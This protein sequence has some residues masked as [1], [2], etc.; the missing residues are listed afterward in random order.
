MITEPLTK[1]KSTGKIVGLIELPGILA[2]KRLY[3]DI[4]VCHCHGVFDLVHVGHLRHFQKAKENGD[5]LVITLTPDRY[6]NKGP[7]RPAFNEEL[8]L[9]FIA[10]LE[11]VDYVALNNWPT[12]IETLGLIKPDFYIKGSEYS[13]SKNDITGMIEAEKHAV[14][15]A[16]GKLVFTDDVIFSS[17][18]LINNYMSLLPEPA[19]RFISQLKEKY[20]FND[21]RKYIEGCRQLNVL[22]LGETIIDEYHY[23]ETM[24]K[25]G[26]EPI[27]AA[28]YQKKEV[29]LGGV[30]AAANH[31]SSFCEN[32]NLL[33]ELGEIDSHF[34]YIKS[35]LK[36]NV[37]P[38]F[39]HLANSPTIIKRR[40]VETYPFQKL[41]EIY[42]MNDHPQNGAIIRLKDKLE[43]LLPN[44]DMVVITDYGH[45]M[46]EKDIIA[47]VCEKAPYI[48]VNTQKNAGN[49]G[50][51][52]VSKYPRADFICI[53]EN[54]LRLD[55]RN[56]SGNLQE[57]TRNLANQ[58]S[59]ENI[60]VT[61]GLQGCLCYNR[62]NGFITAPALTN[63]FKDRVGAGDA[64]FS[65]ASMCAKQK[66][67]IDLLG[68]ISNA[69]G[70]QA[71]EIISNQGTVEKQ[72]LLKHL[73][74]LLK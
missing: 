4:K 74:H 54:E 62:D 53:S 58:L 2:E 65:I 55:A 28:R 15:S 26:K 32:I 17:S 25:S 13:D 56:K 20:T 47:M 48:A 66:V 10:A 43:E 46:I 11:C 19:V 22:V 73:S 12:A 37:K 52:A 36:A 50:F 68:L 70:A 51:N 38:H 71:V 8:R 3:H 27:L 40:F 23:C 45:G 49:H 33:S 63:N 42:I 35:N 59:C 44:I 61:R 64:V 21:I 34:D 60:V 67:P 39:I 7:G 18:N 9:E 14:E 1:S 41:F 57:L 24:G 29:S 5:V 30:L 72:Q 6:V 31:I 16:G 69:V